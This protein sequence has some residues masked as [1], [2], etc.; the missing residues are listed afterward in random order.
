VSYSFQLNHE[1]A[2]AIRN[3][4][5]WLQEAIYD[6]LDRVAA[7][8]STLARHGSRPWGVH[9]F[10]REYQDKRYTTFLAIRPDH[11]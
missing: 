5:I 9:D 8:P 11:V 1:A 10:V 4:E 3:S 7:D 2:N 6:E